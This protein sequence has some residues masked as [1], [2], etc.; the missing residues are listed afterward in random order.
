MT[1]DCAIIGLGFA[2]AFA[3]CRACTAHKDLKIIGFDWG[4][5]PLK[6]RSQSGGYLGYG[7]QSDGKLYTSNLS[8]VSEI[9]GPR[10]ANSANTFVQ[11]ILD[12]VVNFKTIK[13]THPSLS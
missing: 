8:T 11:Q 13:D 12:N 4:R 3:A 7:P 2:G 10:R 6:R 1:F 5:A 9:T